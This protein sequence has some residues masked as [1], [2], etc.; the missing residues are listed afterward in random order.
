MGSSVVLF[1]CSPPAQHRVRTDCCLSRV[2]ITG[3][4]ASDLTNRKH[5]RM[6]SVDRRQICGIRICGL[7]WQTYPQNLSFP[8]MTVK[9]NVT[10]TICTDAHA[11][12]IIFTF[13]FFSADV[14]CYHYRR[15]WVLFSCICLVLFRFYCICMLRRRISCQLVGYWA[16]S[17]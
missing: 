16:N 2:I 17:E 12:K 7:E 1:R 5:H 11:R 6:S 10:W 4:L 14:T 15:N 13:Y 9:Y 3:T 8:W